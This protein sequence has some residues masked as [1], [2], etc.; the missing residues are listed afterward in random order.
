MPAAKISEDKITAIHS[1]LDEGALPGGCL[2]ICG[3]RP[4]DAVELAEAG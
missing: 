3:D 1:T 2:Q 4:E